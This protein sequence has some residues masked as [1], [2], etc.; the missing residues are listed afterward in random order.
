MNLY[1]KASLIITA[2]AYKAGKI[3]AA[4]PT[5]GL[6]DL[7]VTRGGAGSRRN[8]AGVIESL[9][10]NVPALNYPV[11]LACPSWAIQAQRTNLFINPESPV[12]QNITVVSGQVYTI[13]TFGTVTATCSNAGVGSASNN[14]SFTFTA[15]TTTLT[16]TISGLSGQAYVNVGLGAANWITPIMSGAV[17]T[18]RP[19]DVF[20]LTGASALIG[21]TEGT[22]FIEAQLHGQS[23]S[24]GV[25][26][27]LASISDGTVNNRI[28]IYRFNN[29]IYYDHSAGGSVQF[30]GLVFTITDFTGQPLKLALSYTLNNVKVFIN[31]ALV[32]TD[33]TALIPACNRLTIGCNR[34]G[35][36]Q[37]N[38]LIRT[39]LLGPLFTDSECIALTTI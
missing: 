18:T 15:S 39:V 32:N 30:S 23:F 26:R 28:D 29:Q 9:A 6:G 10:N 27:L 11:N 1:E 20:Q 13:T 14:G 7:T 34:D 35:L 22:I 33:T 37:W 5:S 16:V 4:K 31:G 17:S 8:S 12:T 21:Q 36:S 2:N 3:Y 38:G 19:A 25:A 24:D